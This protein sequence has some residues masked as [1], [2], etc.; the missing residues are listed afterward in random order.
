MAGDLNIAG[1]IIQ[2]GS[3]YETHAE[4]IYTTKDYIKMREGAVGGL[5]IGDYSGLEVI[6]YDGTN[7]G[8]I[9]IDN[10]GVMRVGDVG[11]EQPL[12][13]REEAANLTDGALL[14]WDAGNLKA[15]DEGTVGSDLKPIK[16]VNGVATAI[17]NDLVSTQGNQ[18]IA[19]QKTFTNNI[20]LNIANGKGWIDSYYDS[21]QHHTG[22]TINSI[23]VE[24][25]A[26]NCGLF[27]LMDHA[28]GKA[29]LVVRK[30]WNGTTTYNVLAEY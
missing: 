2:Q 24:N 27:I 22:V 20:N 1:D 16:I 25:T 3:S 23:D 15:V 17:T 19:G 6:K 13:T 4:Q 29:R 8:R 30:V 18:I 28:Q 26:N 5:A 10:S 9:C 7:N 11:D 14:K 21:A 12:L